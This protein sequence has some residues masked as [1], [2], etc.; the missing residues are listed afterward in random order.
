VISTEVLAATVQVLA[1]HPATGVAVAAG[2]QSTLR[3]LLVG[4]HFRAVPAVVL[5]EAWP[6]L[7]AATQVAPADRT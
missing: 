7:A 3:D 1:A 6:L 2:V 5:E 4:A